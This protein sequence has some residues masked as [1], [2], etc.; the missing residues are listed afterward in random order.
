MKN[1]RTKLLSIISILT[2]LNGVLF[3]YQSYPDFAVSKSLG[4]G[5]LTVSDQVTITSVLPGTPAGQAQLQV[6]DII[7]TVNNQPITSADE[8]ITSTTS[9]AG[10]EITVGYKRGS[11]QFSTRLTPLL[12]PI[13]GSER[14]GVE[15]INRGVVEKPAYEIIPQVI[16]RSY[17]GYEEYRVNYPSWSEWI[18]AEGPT[19]IEHDKSFSRLQSLIWGIVGVILG[20]GLWKLKKWAYYGFLA[21][22]TYS[23]LLLLYRVIRFPP[24]ELSPTTAFIDSPIVP[25]F[26][27]VLSFLFVIIYAASGFYVYKQKRLFS[28]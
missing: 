20:V 7:T 5:G 19:Y 16:I 28:R 1:K 9:L 18:M 12:V 6:G 21:T 4:Q 14:V 10:Q 15:I 23:L 11:Q 17:A 3:I 2:I 13:P 22:T 8:F 24:W 27:T 26:L 25:V